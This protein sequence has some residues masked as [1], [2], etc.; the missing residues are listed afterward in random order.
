MKDS[1]QQQR[2]EKPR[3]GKTMPPGQNPKQDDSPSHDEHHDENRTNEYGKE[4]AS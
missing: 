1:K 4:Y 3:E 2:E